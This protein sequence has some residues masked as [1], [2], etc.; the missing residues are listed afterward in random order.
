MLWNIINNGVYY[1]LHTNC[2]Q[3]QC[4]G[5]AKHYAFANKIWNLTRCNHK[6]MGNYIS[7][8]AKHGGNCRSSWV[9]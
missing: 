2:I 8:I 9:G 4:G 5:F 1:Q 3:R 7:S 6:D